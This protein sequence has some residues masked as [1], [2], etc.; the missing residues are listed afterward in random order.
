MDPDIGADNVD[1]IKTAPV[2][3]TDRHVVRFTVGDSVHD[4]VEHGCVDKD[5]VVHGEVV[6]LF[7]A[8]EASTVALAI[9]VI[10]ISKAWQAY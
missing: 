2:S 5:N 1:A 3:T 8:Q 10:L 9:L 7:D 6:G 4:K